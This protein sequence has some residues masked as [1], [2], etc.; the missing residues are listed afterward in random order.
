MHTADFGH[1][2]IQPPEDKI[3]ILDQLP[4]VGEL[5][6]IL[7]PLDDDT[8]DKDR[9]EEVIKE[10]MKSVSHYQEAYFAYLRVKTD[11]AREV[12]G[13][14]YYTDESGR[15][16][17]LEATGWE[18]Y[19]VGCRNPDGSE[20]NSI[21]IVKAIAGQGLELRRSIHHIGNVYYDNPAKPSTSSMLKVA[22]GERFDDLEALKE[23]NIHY[24]AMLGKLRAH[25]T[26]NRP[27]RLHEAEIDLALQSYL[28]T[29]VITIATDSDFED[30]LKKNA[31][32]H[33][34]TLSSLA[35]IPSIAFKFNGK[36][37]TTTCILPRPSERSSE[38]TNFERH[39]VRLT[40][41]EREGHKLASSI[42]LLG[43]PIIR[44]TLSLL[45]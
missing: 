5:L 43:N 42:G 21:D 3:A 17:E 24:G 34:K 30:D 31:D 29:G 14:P 40:H 45:G 19:Y 13:I 38:R 35:D 15:E 36:A 26:E 10:F 44:A 16:V 41:D 11:R 6:D 12:V 28:N 33:Q 8:E 32:F 1:Q 23:V 22:S 4:Y 20:M 7:L 25:I 37:I 27:I 39:T 18:G 9:Q 2:A